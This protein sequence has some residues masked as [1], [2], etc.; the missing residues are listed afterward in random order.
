MRFQDLELLD[1]ISFKDG[2]IN[3][4]GRRL[5]LHSIHAFSQ[6]R[7]DIVKM[8]GEENARR[9]FT[10][11][12]FFWGQANA[13]A[14]QRLFKWTNIEDWI[15]AGLKLHALEGVVQTTVSNMSIDKK[16]KR[17]RM[18]ISWHDSVEVEE[19]LMDFGPGNK[20]I[21]WKLTG[22]ISGL[23]SYC[24]GQ[25]IYFVES[26]CQGKKD[27]VCKAIGKD[28]IS[29]GD[30]I[31]PHL[32]Y[33]EAED[34]KGTVQR[35]SQELRKKTRALNKHKRELKKL[36]KQ[37]APY[38]F[39]GRTKVMQDVLALANQV[40]KFDSSVLIT[41]ETGT[42]K[43]VLARY[44]HDAS[45]RSKAPFVPIN[46]VALPESLLDSELFG[47]KAGS[48]TGAARD[49]VGLIEAA[50]KGTVFLDEIGDISPSTQLKILRVL[51]EKEIL[52]VGENK[53]RKTDVRV[54]AATNK[55]LSSAVKYQE[56]REDLLYRLSVVEILM[57]PL[58]ERREDILPLSKFLI[59]RIANR[60]GLNFLKLD[61][62]CAEYLTDYNWPG[63]V[64]ELENTLERAAVVS[65]DGIILPKHLPAKIISQKQQFNKNIY[66]SESNL[67]QVEMA[68]IKQV[69]DSTGG[70]RR[71]A[72]KILGISETTLWRRLKDQA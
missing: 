55:D 35:L 53:P 50:S 52:R 40:A 31:S 43:E 27:G 41:G 64:R 49:R 7:Y 68:Y 30:E 48:F 19:H 33:F 63:N 4:R 54:I 2:D 18:E 61:T 13:A 71:K 38:L 1:L 29:W 60:L 69:L 22:Y 12:G 39:E 57:P 36:H 58:R 44:I 10:R 72:S 62:T 23:T 65:I 5:V 20:T 9:L 25:S 47:H 21:C 8:L 66:K 45:Y 67:M 42:G 59:D 17:F 34:I 26:Q 3:L 70:N 6:F 24:M 37:F 11:F 15:Q 14:L 51:Q 28:F 16:N 32:I 56:F 46:C